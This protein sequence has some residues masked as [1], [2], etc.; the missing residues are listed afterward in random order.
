[1]S[2]DPKKDDQKTA[3]DATEKPRPKRVV[4]K[5]LRA[6]RGI[7]NNVGEPCGFPPEM[8][9]KLLDKNRIGGPLAELYN[10]EKK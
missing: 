10:P 7:V 2:T 5:L 1:M 3:R 4:V 8:A 6:V 9:A